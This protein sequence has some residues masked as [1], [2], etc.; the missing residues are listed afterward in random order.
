MYGGYGGDRRPCHEFSASGRCRYGSTC[1]FS[2]DGGPP[3]AAVREAPREQRGKVCTHYAATGR[4]SY[5]SSCKFLHAD[6]EWR[7]QGGGGEAAQPA[8]RQGQQAPPA[9][10]PAQQPQQH[11]PAQHQPPHRH[12]DRHDQHDQPRGGQ[13]PQPEQPHQ[14]QQHQQQQ[15]QQQAELPQH[16]KR[17]GLTYVDRLRALCSVLSIGAV[18]DLV[19]S[20]AMM[21]AIRSF[22]HGS[23]L[24]ENRFAD[25]V[26]RYL[27]TQPQQQG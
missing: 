4:C 23:A 19:T 16:P 15:H 3:P 14:Q 2:H 22:Q 8:H 11:M 5:G 13:R 21:A 6:P 24:K 17:G 1:K 27:Q 10:Y 18:G 7:Y 9:L 26:E 12:H 20:E 25:G